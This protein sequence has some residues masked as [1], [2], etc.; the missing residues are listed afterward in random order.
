M[1][2]FFSFTN[3]ITRRKNLFDGDEQDIRSRVIRTRS[4]EDLAEDLSTG[5]WCLLSLFLR[6]RLIN[7]RLVR[8]LK[9]PGGRDKVGD[10][11]K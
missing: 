3:S 10:P 4:G 11:C 2:S 5:H 6:C 9:I 7:C 1:V 8:H